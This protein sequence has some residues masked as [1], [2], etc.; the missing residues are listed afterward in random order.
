MSARSLLKVYRSGVFYFPSDQTV[1]IL[2]T[3]FI[4]AETYVVGNIVKVKPSAKSASQEAEII[5]LSGE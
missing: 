4:E 1:M 5:A 2:A 3:K